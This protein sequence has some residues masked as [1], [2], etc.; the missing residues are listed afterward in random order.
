MKD[1]I[2]ITS[3]VNIH[4]KNYKYLTHGCLNLIN[5]QKE[6]VFNHPWENYKNYKK[7]I[8]K[9]EKIENFIFKEIAKTLNNYHKVN[10]DLRFWNILIGPWLHCFIVAYYEKN[11]LISNLLK[12]KKKLKIPII[13]YQAKKQIPKDFYSFFGN[14]L[15]SANWQNYLFTKIISKNK[16][17][18]NFKTYKKNID[19]KEKSYKKIVKKSL[20]ILF[21][22]VIKKLL[23]LIFYIRIKSQKLVLFNTSLSLKNNL[24]LIFKNFCVPFE[25]E[26]DSRKNSPNIFLR[27]FLSKLGNNKVNLYREI[28]EIAILNI[29]TDFLENFSIIKKEIYETNIALKPNIIFTSNG[30]LPLSYQTRYIAEC[31][32]NGTKLIIAQHGGRYGNIKNFFH[33]EHEI[34]ISDYFISWGKNKNQKKIKNFGITRPINKL[35]YNQR[36]KNFNQ[37]ILF[38]MISKGRFTR[39]IDSEINLKKLYTYYNNFC[40]EFYSFLDKKHQ[41]KLIYRSNKNNFWNEKEILLKKCKQAKIDFNHH[42][43]NL[44]KAASDSKIAV[45]SYFSTTF[46]ELMAANIPVILFTPFTNEGYNSETVKTFNLLSK[47]KIFFKSHKEAANFINKSWNDIDHWWY[48]KKVQN[49]RKKL[50]DN[51]SIANKNLIFDIQKL[52]DANKIKNSLFK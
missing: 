52:I 42:D 4:K 6:V 40:P 32:S 33:L 28:Y 34:K 24:F 11:L 25:I 39:G 20:I 49:S 22:K 19:K 9:I 46:L 5:E 50:L 23:R 35:N 29:P 43:S 1:S 14:K 13:N 17:N 48:S 21:K 27:K 47:N 2:L 30:I 37:N 16:L 31:I 12:Y 36:K 45:C 10:K 18:K 7:D 51:F 15:Y 38:L 26:I 44:F 3:K 8:Q 41:N